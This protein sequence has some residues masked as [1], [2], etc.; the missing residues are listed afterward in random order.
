V[1]GDAAA[2]A[3]IVKAFAAL[4]TNTLYLRLDALLETLRTG[5]SDSYSTLEGT[6][7]SVPAPGVLA[8]DTGDNLM[9]TPQVA[10]ATSQ[11]GTVT[12]NADGSFTYTPLTGF[13]GV[14]TF[15]YTVTNSSGSST[16]TVSI[17]VSKEG[18]TVS[19]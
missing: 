5:V 17:T 9:A 10:A 12:L 16:A 19:F 8:I 3:D 13:I 4:Q 18:K 2:N 14:D 6:A 7:L 11:G 1:P 15:T